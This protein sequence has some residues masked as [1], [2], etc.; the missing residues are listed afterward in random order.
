MVHPLYFGNK[1]DKNKEPKV[2]DAGLVGLERERPPI[3]LTRELPPE[4]TSSPTSE[5]VPS[6]IADQTSQA[7]SQDASQSVASDMGQFDTYQTGILD[8]MIELTRD[9]NPD[10]DYIYADLQNP[11]INGTVLGT[12]LDVAMGIPSVIATNGHIPLRNGFI[13]GFSISLP[14]QMTVGTGLHFRVYRNTVATQCHFYI[15]DGDNFTNPDTTAGGTKRTREFNTVPNVY[16]GGE[17]VPMA[18]PFK[19]GERIAV[20]T[21]AV[22]LSGYVTAD[23]INFIHLKLHRVYD[24]TQR[25]T[26]IALGVGGAGNEGAEGGGIITV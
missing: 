10:W 7:V 26:L 17:T 21:E 23:D 24:I 5:A 14:Q 22:D 2:S 6:T 12:I 3:G 25:E 11:I 8:R 4:S 18:F 16:V 15:T 9:Q 1:K 13:A 19:A 20:V